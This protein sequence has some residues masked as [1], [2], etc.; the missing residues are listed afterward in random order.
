[1]KSILKKDS[2][3]LILQCILILS[4]CLANFQPVPIAFFRHS[5]EFSWPHMTAYGRILYYIS[6]PAAVLLH[7][8]AMTLP[9][10]HWDSFARIQHPPA[11]HHFIPRCLG[12]KH[13]PKR[14]FHLK[15]VF[16]WRKFCLF[17]RRKFSRSSPSYLQNFVLCINYTI[18]FL[19]YNIIFVNY[20]QYP[21]TAWYIPIYQKC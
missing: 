2:I 16:L 18:Y 17:L 14:A 12:S 1:M 6:E 21:S 5:C 10:R 11:L 9:M 15:Q 8:S 7:C 3:N 13:V 19:A 4:G 20:T